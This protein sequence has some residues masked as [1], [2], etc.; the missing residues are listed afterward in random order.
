MWRRWPSTAAT[1]R[2][3]GILIAA[4]CSLDTIR[5]LVD[6]CSLGPPSQDVIE[7]YKAAFAGEDRRIGRVATIADSTLSSFRSSASG[8]SDH[9]LFTD[10][11]EAYDGCSMM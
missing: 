6:A 2:T 11:Q 3:G 9:R 8:V 10:E 7:A 5:A 1:R 4:G